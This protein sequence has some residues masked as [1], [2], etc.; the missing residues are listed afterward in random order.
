MK[1]K[2]SDNIWFRCA[3]VSAVFI[4]LNIILWYFDEFLGLSLTFLLLFLTIPATVISIIAL[5]QSFS[6]KT[7]RH[8]AVFSL[9][10][11]NI[12]LIAV[13]YF[14]ILPHRD[15][16]E[17]IMEDNYTK[18]YAE[19]SELKN[20]FKNAIDRNKSVRMEWS[21]KYNTKIK[22]YD[23]LGLTKQEVKT[24]KKKLRKINCQGIEGGKHNVKILFK[25]VDSGVYY[26]NLSDSVFDLQQINKIKKDC[27]SILLNDSVYFSRVGGAIG[28]YCF[29]N[30]AEFEKR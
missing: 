6:F 8:T 16:D 11:L 22:D 12:I 17:Y 14:A 24:I 4:L 2:L 1:I 30:K 13:F 23:S 5:C 18:H 21:L 10:M 19:M 26:Y 15:C 7:H 3:V 9:N 28:N 27:S 20:Y 25:R 29:E